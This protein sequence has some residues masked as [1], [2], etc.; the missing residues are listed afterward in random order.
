MT[1][2]DDAI[3]QRDIRTPSTAS[4]AAAASTTTTEAT[5]AGN[6][7][8]TWH[9]RHA[10]PPARRRRGSCPS[11]RY[12]HGAATVGSATAIGRR[13][14]IACTGAAAVGSLRAITAS[15]GPVATTLGAIR[16]AGTIAATGPVTRARTIAG[17]I[18]TTISGALA[19]TLV[20]TQHLLS[21]ATTEIGS[22]GR[23]S[24]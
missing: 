6:P 18:S 13:G 20:G 3:L 19:R 24:L 8:A 10:R 9:T 12:I 16:C 22:A 7:A 17:A 21:V 5:A 1:E 4:A 23:A 11:R 2:Q 14:S 15:L